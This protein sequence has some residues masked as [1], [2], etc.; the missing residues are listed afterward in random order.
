MKI[1]AVLDFLYTN[2]RRV[3][4]QASLLTVLTKSRNPCELVHGGVLPSSKFQLRLGRGTQKLPW[5]QV[6]SYLQEFAQLI[7]IFSKTIDCSTRSRPAI[8]EGYFISCSRSKRNNTPA[9]LNRNN[10]SV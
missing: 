10:S 2:N 9:E 8:T 7:G 3:T 5:W 4:P 1:V 6:D